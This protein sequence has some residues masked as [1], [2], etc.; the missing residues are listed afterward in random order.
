M[1]NTANNIY[2]ERNTH[3]IP[4][5]HT[6]D[7]DFIEHM[8]GYPHGWTSIAGMDEKNTRSMVKKI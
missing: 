5:F 1:N 4:K 6:I 8:M 3:A 2:Y 7:P